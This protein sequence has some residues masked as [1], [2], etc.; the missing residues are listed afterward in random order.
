[1][2]EESFD[3]FEKYEEAQKRT[4]GPKSNLIN[5]VLGLCGESGEVAD[6]IKKKEFQ[7][8]P[9]DR[10]KLVEELGDVLWYLS[11]AARAIDSNL[12]E[13]ARANI[14]KLRKRY[15]D[16]FSEERSIFREK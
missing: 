4:S 10:E 14:E 6:L 1:M 11:E 15:P 12:A 9:L 13:I 16:G 3:S 8:H 5:S 7:G 2:V